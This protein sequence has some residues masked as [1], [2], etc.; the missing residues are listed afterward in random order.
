MAELKAEVKSIQW[1]AT[2][3]SF[4]R[5][6]TALN[7]VGELLREQGVTDFKTVEDK[8]FRV[9]VDENGNIRI[10]GQELRVDFK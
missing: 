9:Q 7:R 10:V 2:S 6:D 4:N 5:L 1:A 8:P 3:E